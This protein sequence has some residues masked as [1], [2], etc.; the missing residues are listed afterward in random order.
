MVAF[1]FVGVGRPA[2]CAR[3]VMAVEVAVAG[4]GTWPVA[5][6]MFCLDPGA[7]ALDGGS[8]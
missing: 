3:M 2:G 8:R 5:V 4:G 1:F 6:A 7:V